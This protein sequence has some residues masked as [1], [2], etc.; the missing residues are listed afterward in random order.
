MAT[1]TRES[2]GTISVFSEGESSIALATEGSY[3]DKNIV[4]NINSPYCVNPNLLDNWYFPNP[5]NQRNFSKL[6]GN[7]N[8]NFC[9]D[10]WYH[11]S[12]TSSNY[13]EKSSNYI[14]MH[15][16]S[17]VNRIGQRIPN[18]SG[19][20]TLSVLYQID[21]A[22]VDAYI[23]ENGTNKK[24]GTLEPMQGGIWMNK[25][26]FTTTGITE[27]FLQGVSSSDAQINLYAIKLEIGENQTLAH[28]ESGYWKLN[29]IPNFHDELLRCMSFYYVS[30]ISYT[31]TWGV[32]S[33]TAGTTT[34]IPGNKF[35]V[36]MYSAPSIVFRNYV[37]GA[38]NSVAR[39]KD[40][41]IVSGVTP[42]RVTTQSF[43]VTKAGGFAIEEV[44]AWQMEAIVPNFGG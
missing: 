20:L 35:I 23:V 17:G 33:G 3:L 44:Y 29:S 42:G 9:I 30:N 31:S 7:G 4:F 24:I 41:A 32:W 25:F 28:K 43:D 36:P 12:S 34:T 1:T 16:T 14:I 40:D 6:Y 27:I 37:N 19:T 15:Q 21:G 38:A 8:N 39:W 10:R 2:D 11:Y 26:T 18:V 22:T 13:I 5:I